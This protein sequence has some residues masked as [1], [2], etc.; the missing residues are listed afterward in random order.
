LDRLDSIV[1]SPTTFQE[2][3]EGAGDLRI[4]WIDGEFWAVHISSQNG[5]HPEDSRLDLSVKY[6]A[7]T[8]S[9]HVQAA[10]QLLM[11]ELGLAFG[12]I[13]MR[14]DK[15][16]QCYFLEVN[17]AGQFAYLE[18]KTGLPLTMSLASALSRGYSRLRDPNVMKVG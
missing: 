14:L 16:G 12:A 4:I 6:S 3:I 2:Y 5:K 13:D 17:P 1:G 7:Y 8:L 10:L 15:G 9:D 18:V 11:V